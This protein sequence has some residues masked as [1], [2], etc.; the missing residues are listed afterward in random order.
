MLGGTL[1]VEGKK[2][3][4]CCILHHACWLE[5]VVGGSMESEDDLLIIVD[6]LCHAVMHVPHP[7]FE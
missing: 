4:G 2:M 5:R 6:C 1:R 3:V 7:V